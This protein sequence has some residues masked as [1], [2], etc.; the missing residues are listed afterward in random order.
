MAC[1][2]VGPVTIM[3]VF[4][5]V[6]VGVIASWL[7]D[8]VGAEEYETMYCRCE[9]YG[10]DLY[11]RTFIMPFIVVEGI[12][13]IPW[14]HGAC[15]YN[16]LY[17]PSGGQMDYGTPNRHPSAAARQRLFNAGEKQKKNR[18]GTN[19]ETVDAIAAKISEVSKKRKEYRQ[20]TNEEIKGGFSN[21]NEKQMENRKGASNEETVDATAARFS[22]AN[23]K[24]KEYG[25]GTNEET[26]D[27]FF[28]AREKQKENFDSTAARF[29]DASKK[30][31]EY[32]QGTNEETDDGFFDASE[33]QEETF[34]AS[35]TA[36]RFSDASKKQKEFRTNEETNANAAARIS[37][38]SEKRNRKGTNE[39]T[40]D[41]KAAVRHSNAS[42]KQ[43]EYR[44]GTNEGEK[45]RTEFGHRKL[46]TVGQR[47]LP[48]HEKRTS[49]GYD[50]DSP[51][52]GY[53]LFSYGK[54]RIVF[55]CPGL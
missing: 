17:R 47:R 9:E 55:R 45:Q 16:V 18:Q 23:K 50:G 37:S 10:E 15:R 30:Q 12:T 52:T 6:F 51:R 7:W 54:D 5:K 19:E 32:R 11:G 3:K 33:K 13:V 28:D 27:E 4:L 41:T 24:Q 22:D 14:Y 35:A 31:K 21:A 2:S 53:D 1:T 49:K 40:E 20:E 29:S 43:N 39:E 38:A 25:Q 8:P 48:L 46:F 42:D 36:A 44:R 26:D 34:D